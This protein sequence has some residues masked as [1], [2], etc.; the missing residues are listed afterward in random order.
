MAKPI[1]WAVA[2]FTVAALYE[3]TQLLRILF[4]MWEPIANQWWKIGG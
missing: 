3:A 4:W 2:F 1:W